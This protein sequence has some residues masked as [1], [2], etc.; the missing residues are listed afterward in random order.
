MK[1][2]LSKL[3]LAALLPILAVFG[4]LDVVAQSKPVTGKP[5]QLKKVKTGTSS[6][7]VAETPAKPL[8][9]PQAAPVSIVNLAEPEYLSGEARVMVNPKQ[10]TV[11]RLGLAQN[12]VSIVEF[13]ASD[14]IYYIHEGNPKLA[15][16]FQSP[17]KETDRSITIYPGESFLPSRDGSSASSISL[18]MRSGLVLILELVPV[19]DLRKNAHRCV[20]TYD[21]DA[22]ISA[23]R[24][25]G[26][27]YEL[28]GENAST[29]PINSRAVSKLVGIAS[30]SE[31]VRGEK[32]FEKDHPLN[33]AIA[34]LGN[35]N[36]VRSKNSDRRKTTGE[37][38]ALANKKLAESMREPKKHLGPFSKPQHGLELAVSRVTELDPETR[39]VVVAVRN[40]TA[41]NLRLVPGSPE[42]QIQTTDAAGNGIQTTRPDVRYLES[43]TL[44]GL[45]QPGSTVSYALVYKAPI[46]GTN[47]T[48]RILVAHREA[49]DAP[50][51]LSL[52]DPKEKE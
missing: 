15:S 5:K 33:S 28:G 29:T 45:V 10:P 26:L 8:L 35:S 1:T 25:A 3:A 31:A 38:S 2:N 37:I 48:V 32:P 39:L 20:I 50:L 51:A 41:S 21:R 7:P 18:Q 12:A 4:G 19:T 27:A 6:S 42:L 46:L 14:G 36:N 49:A 13:P 40:I 43:T 17:T 9:S 30:T 34:D 44:D 16:V 24:A 23:R 52:G 22:V 11:I 47:Q